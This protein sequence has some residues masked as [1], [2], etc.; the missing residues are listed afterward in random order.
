MSDS[1][2]DSRTSPKSNKHQVKLWWSVEPKPG[3]FGDVLG[4]WL[5][6]KMGL[7][8]HW[9]HH[10]NPGVGL[11]TGSI[12]RFTQSTS[13]VWGAGIMDRDVVGDARASYH[14]VRG[15]LT[16]EAILKTG[17]T[18]PPVYGDP[19]L[20]APRY[21]KPQVEKKYRLGVMYHYTDGPATLGAKDV[22][23]W[24]LTE[25]PEEV[26][27]VICSCQEIHSSSLHG[28]VI[29][30]AYGI[31]WKWIYSPNVCGEGVKFADFFA[32][33]VLLDLDALEAA[34]PW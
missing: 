28:L 12:V 2:A 32:S 30:E 4:P 16:R 13:V 34:C 1:L 8:V 6:R 21:Y 26:I 29:A 7:D 19:G 33:L 27:D 9:T 24:P 14:A 20:L 31:P 22:A 23:I 15:P 18:C 25:N 5:L 17:G 10:Q 11:S 3:N